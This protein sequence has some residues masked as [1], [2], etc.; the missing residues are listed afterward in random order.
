M[1]GPI[2][3]G[4][5]S[6]SGHCEEDV[7]ATSKEELEKKLTEDWKQEVRNVLKFIDDSKLDMPL[8]RRIQ[9]QFEKMGL[10]YDEMQHELDSLRIEKQ[11]LIQQ[12][13][14]V[15]A[16][17]NMD[18][19]ELRKEIDQLKEQLAKGGSSV[20]VT[21]PVQPPEVPE[22]PEA[23]EAPEVLHIS[24]LSK[25]VTNSNVMD[26]A[27]KLSTSSVEVDKHENSKFLNVM[28]FLGDAQ[29]S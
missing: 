20:P 29:S 1:E 17:S 15:E 11:Q 4:G 23:P 18:L 5:L 24:D 8:M 27:Y 13:A 19:E 22:V 21:A 7:F 26:E 6:V 25:P 16:Q 12:K 9:E 14:M 2:Y 10:D 3:F 28:L